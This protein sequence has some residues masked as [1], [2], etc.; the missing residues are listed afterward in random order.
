MQNKP[1]TTTHFISFTGAAL[2][3][4]LVNGEQE[5]KKNPMWSIY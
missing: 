3:L 1:M 4:F 2:L 5:G